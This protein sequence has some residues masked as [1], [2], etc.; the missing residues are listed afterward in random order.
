MYCSADV[1][2]YSI[3]VVSKLAKLR[4]GRQD[5]E[6]RQGHLYLFLV[7]TS[8]KTVGVIQPPK[9]RVLSIL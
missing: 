6:S 4:G 5:F 2:F 9:H 8:T 1:H 3:L 7:V